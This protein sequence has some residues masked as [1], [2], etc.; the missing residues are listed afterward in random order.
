MSVVEFSLS[1]GVTRYLHTFIRPDDVPM[2]YGYI[3]QKNSQDSHRIDLDI[4]PMNTIAAKNPSYAVRKM[5]DMICPEGTVHV[6]PPLYT[7]EVS[8]AIKYE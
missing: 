2:G 1:K 6:M 7:L 4:E 3:I 8:H 5:L